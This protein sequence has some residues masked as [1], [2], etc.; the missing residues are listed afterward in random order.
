[1]EEARNTKFKCS[2]HFFFRVPVSQIEHVHVSLG[3]ANINNNVYFR[4]LKYSIYSKGFCDLTDELYIE[5][6]QFADTVASGNK[7]GF[8]LSAAKEM[9]Q[10]KL[11]NILSIIVQ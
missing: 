2:S 3:I 10:T 7:L 11:Q 8:K 1:M 9:L 5:P 6:H 4:I